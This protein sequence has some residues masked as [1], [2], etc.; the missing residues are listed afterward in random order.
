MKKTKKAL[1]LVLCLMVALCALPFSLMASADEEEGEAYSA[2]LGQIYDSTAT[3][4]IHEDFYKNL[5]QDVS[6]ISGI[7]GANVGGMGYGVHPDANNAVKNLVFAYDAGE[8]NLLKNVSVTFK[9]RAIQNNGC[10]IR[11][12]Y[13]FSQDP[14]GKWFYADGIGHASD[15]YASNNT[16]ITFSLAEELGKGVQKLYIKVEMRRSGSASWTFLTK[17]DVNARKVAG[18]QAESAESI[19]VKGVTDNAVTLSKNSEISFTAKAAPV[20]ISNTAVTADVADSNIATASVNG[21]TVTVKGLEL[22]TT[23]IILESVLNPDVKK[24]I[25]VNV[26]GIENDYDAAVE[27]DIS[28]AV[29][30]DDFLALDSSIATSPIANEKGATVKFPAVSFAN[31]TGTGANY[32]KA[33]VA[34]GEGADAAASWDVYVDSVSDENLLAT[35]YAMPYGSGITKQTSNAYLNDTLFGTHDI[36]VVYNT[37]GS[38]VY[39]ITFANIPGSYAEKTVQDFTALSGYARTKNLVN[40]SGV[41]SETGAVTSAQRGKATLIYRLDA[42]EGKELTSADIRLSF[43]NIKGTST[44]YGTVKAA[45]STDFKN[46]NEIY[47]HDGSTGDKGDATASTYEAQLN[48]SDTVLGAQTAYIMV[49]VERTCNNGTA[50]WHALFGFYLEGKTAALANIVRGDADG[51]GTVNVLDLIRFK[52]AAANIDTQIADTAYFAGKN[53]LNADVI[54]TK[55]TILGA[56]FTVDRDRYVPVAAD[57][58]IIDDNSPTP[59]VFEAFD[60]APASDELEAATINTARINFCL[61]NY[62][63][64]ILQSGETYDLADYIKITAANT[65]FTTDGEEKANLEFGGDANYTIKVEGAGSEISNLYVNMNFGYASLSRQSLD[66]SVVAISAANVKVDNCVIEGGPEPETK[67]IEFVEGSRSTGV[68][69]LKGADN[70]VVSNS[71]IRNCYYGVIF[72]DQLTSDTN[73]TVEKCDISYNRADGVTFSGYGIVRNSKISYNGYDCLNGGEYGSPIPGAGVYAEGSSYGFVVEGCEI[74]RNN[75]FNIDVNRG[76]N[77]TIKDNLLYDSG[78]TEFPLAAD[79]TSVSYRNGVSLALS[80]LIN[81]TVT[82]NRVINN[83]TYNRLDESYANKRFKNDVNGF[84]GYG[85]NKVAFSSLPTGGASIV[86]AFLANNSKGNKI[87]GNTFVSSGSGSDVTGYGF[88]IAYSCDTDNDVSGN[89]YEQ[90]DT[91]MID[92]R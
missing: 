8:G 81:S 37:V 47:V 50:S 71:I 41:Y 31:F 17:L 26:K 29:N 54:Y 27:A 80:G 30:A 83:E 2:T 75:G 76:S 11:V 3:N 23:K 25:T 82:G 68:Y 89:V 21:E 57:T 22:G 65:K 34:W 1:S 61:E 55:K 51:N 10:Y 44:L 14:A 39:D 78:W 91:D 79:Y 46:W 13:G 7:K 67:D 85:V 28:N 69:F 63:I 45:V 62:G 59:T 15:G 72:N 48:E 87:N 64:C 19:A 90:C 9:G 53:N 52:K 49:T 74:F 4:L 5:V 86:A 88:F 36:Y 73:C 92:A 66:C 24:E 38:A 56:E 32:I 77:I 18:T 43:R 16:Q 12:Y 60:L 42:G 40:Y 35:L 20:Y 84:F 33:T 70:S 6:D 58:V